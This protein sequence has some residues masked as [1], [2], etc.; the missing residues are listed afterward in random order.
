MT[1]AEVKTAVK[2]A[3]ADRADEEGREGNVVIFGLSEEA[4]ENISQKVSEI[5]TELNEKPIFGAKRIGLKKSDES[6]RPVKVEMKSCAAVNQILAKTSKLRES[7]EFSSVY[8]SPDRTLEQRA[9]HRKLVVEVKRRRAEE[10]S[11][12]HYI[13]GEIVE[14]TDLK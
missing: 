13:R 14:S 11:K 4:N 1:P 3:L 8:I 7:A 9:T 6:K 12:R 2:T 10:P 5:F